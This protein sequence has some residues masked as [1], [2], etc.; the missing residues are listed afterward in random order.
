MDKRLNILTK[1][2]P[3]FATEA[4]LESEI[5]IVDTHFK[6]VTIFPQDKSDVKRDLPRAIK[7]DDALITS[8]HKSYGRNI[9]N[10]LSFDFWRA[11]FEH[12]KQ[13][14]SLKDVKTIFIF[15]SRSRLI[16]KKL[17]SIREKL[18]NSIIYTYWF[19]DVVY[20][21][22]KLRE[23]GMIQNAVIISRAH[24]YDLYEGRTDSFHFWPYRQYCV[25]NIDKLFVISR[26]G[27]NFIEERYGAGSNVE[28]SRLGVSNAG[29][30]TKASEDELKIVS[31]AWISER[32]RIDLV[33]K[34]IKEFASKNEH[35]K[36]TWIHFGDGPLMEK[37]TT[38]IKSA[39]KTNNLEV[40]LKGKVPNSEIIEFYKNEAVDL[41][42]N[43]SSSEGVPVSIMEAQSFGIPVLA[44]DVG[45]TSEIVNNNV[46]YLVKSDPEITEVVEG[47]ESIVERKIPRTEV[48]KN[49][50]EC[51]DAEK[52]YNEFAKILKNLPSK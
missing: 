24:R 2:F 48:Q 6:N 34:C 51:F 29:V 43:L 32:K 28:I 16:S 7:V 5:K 23:K 9:G 36:V 20:A 30:L 14:R 50:A 39:G 13:I 11:V 15:V 41:F 52:N 44:T 46:G 21:L 37:I 31:A 18:S 35:L 47:L 4:F 22:L 26:D 10:V 1:R 19:N 33:F 38:L 40:E 27:K 17:V 8:Y 45:A 25:N 12:R 3:Y 42:I 49:W